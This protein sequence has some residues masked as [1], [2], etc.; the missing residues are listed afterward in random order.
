M[1]K[2]YQVFISSTSKDLQNARQ[3][4]SQAL[5]R[6]D[7]FPAQMELWPAADEEQFE[8]IK[9]IIRQCDYYIVISAGMYGSIH[10]QTGLS[11]TEMEFDYAREVGIPT[12]RLLHKDPFKL[13]K[14]SQIE[15]SDGARE[16][17]KSFRGK[18]MEGRLCAF[19]ES[20]TE[21]G[22]EV[23]FSLTDIKQR[24]PAQGWVKANEVASS[25]ALV[26]I[27]DLRRQLSE[28]KL[29]Q[30]ERSRSA[31]IPKVLDN[32]SGKVTLF[33]CDLAEG[34]EQ[35]P[36]YA[37]TYQTGFH[38]FLGKAY[39]ETSVQIEVEAS[40]FA[41]KILF[42]FL[43]TDDLKGATLRAFASNETDPAGNPVKVFMCARA[44][45]LQDMFMKLES[46]GIV[47]A[48]NRDPISMAFATEY[49]DS[50]RWELT[51]VG[52]E[53]ILANKPA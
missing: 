5:L 25:E 50:Y 9:Q 1:D 43:F 51:G 8:F 23:I 10:P 31:D 38:N 22:R 24:R 49:V 47:K 44:A 7:C 15:A 41:H 53:W 18:L 3:E 28:S 21:L 14:G 39:K 46:E 11:Y 6:S 33:Q 29:H 19:W 45:E 42:G 17:L 52:R 12:I 36:V 20:P 34:E 16:K 30:A 27:A 26:E 35:D 32:I 37:E 13:L 2:R 4:V 48:N 40:E